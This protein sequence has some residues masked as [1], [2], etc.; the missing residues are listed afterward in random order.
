[1]TT[2]PK[3][4]PLFG[5]PKEGET[6]GTNCS[7][8]A[9]FTWRPKVTPSA[10]PPKLKPW[11]YPVR[12]VFASPEKRNTSSSRKPREKLPFVP[13]V[14]LK[15]D[16]STTRK[17]PAGIRAFVVKRYLF[18]V[19]ESSVRNQPVISTAFVVGLNNSTVSRPEGGGRERISLT[20]MGGIVA[21][22]S[23]VPGEPPG[24]VLA[25]Q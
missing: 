21:G 22:G 3:R 23:S 16:S 19:P 13:G 8:P 11:L 14:G 20:T 12:F 10:V 9:L 7:M 24:F 5:A 4:G 2:G 1:M 6:C 15:F 17:P 25:R 18:G